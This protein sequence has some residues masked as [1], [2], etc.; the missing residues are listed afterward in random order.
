MYRPMS[1]ERT[2]PIRATGWVGIDD[3]G[4]RQAVVVGDELSDQIGVRSLLAEVELG[5]KMR[6]DL[7][8]ERIELEQPSGLG[9]FLEEGGAEYP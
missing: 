1:A 8:G 4:H 6:L 2:K 5:S 9:P 3:R 7:V